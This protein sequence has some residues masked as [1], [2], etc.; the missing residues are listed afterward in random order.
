M[1]AVFNCKNVE[2][3]VERGAKNAIAL[4]ENVKM[5]QKNHEGQAMDKAKHTLPL[6]ARDDMHRV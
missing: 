2:Y 6:N 4:E 3:N 5:R 1:H